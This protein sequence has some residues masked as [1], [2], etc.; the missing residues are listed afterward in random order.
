MTISERSKLFNPQPMFEIMS[1]A[2]KHE[3][4]GNEIIHLEIGDTSKFTN[5]KL[6]SIIKKNINNA[7]LGY[8]LSQ[9]DLNLRKK[10]AEQYTERLNKKITEEH[11]VISPANSLVTTFLSIITDKNDS[12]LIPDP[13]FPT[14][15]LAADALNLK[16][17]FYRLNKENNYIPNLIEIENK[18][19][20]NKKLKV[21]IINSPSNPLGNIIPV[22]VV[23]KIINLAKMN[24]LFCMVDETY[25]NLIYSEDKHFDLYF[26]NIIFIHSFSKEAAAPG[27]RMGFGIANK[28]IICRASNLN[29]LFFSCQPIF[30]QK[31]ILE[32]INTSNSFTKKI[33]LDLK[34]RAR[35]C[36]K[37]LIKCKNI[38]FVEPQGGIFI[39]IDISMTGLDGNE[40]ARRLLYK[41]L[42]CVCP[43]ENFG[44]S[45]KN[46]VRINMAG[47][48]SELYKGCQY[49]VD[50]ANSL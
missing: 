49:I 10:I 41:K 45:G 22:R 7:N 37:I 21:I 26:Q 47:N 48:K 40:F 16:K 27:L 3:L 12:V 19:K 31:S 39:F 35:I 42:L 2:H 4:K 33:R 9:G 30:L 14:Y 29:S 15:Q 1:L 44:P 38:S 50:M 6:I 24:N 5:N 13:G 46:Y 20:K 28:E 23:K 8:T 34:S 17:I 43:G 36:T 18:I 25:K 32:Y 11:V